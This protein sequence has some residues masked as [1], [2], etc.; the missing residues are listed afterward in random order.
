VLALLGYLVALIGDEQTG[1]W[2]G[3]VLAAA[4]G[5]LAPV[6]F[7]LLG[8]LLTDPRAG[9]GAALARTPAMAFW[10]ALLAL[11]VLP[12]IRL[13]VRGPRGGTEPLPLATVAR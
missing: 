2:Y 12:G 4:M 9:V 11:G 10:S 6:L 3:A 13:L 7:N 1:V 8:V 5:A